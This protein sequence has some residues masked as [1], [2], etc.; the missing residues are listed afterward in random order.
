M[1]AREQRTYKAQYYWWSQAFTEALI[2][3]PANKMKILFTKTDATL[4]L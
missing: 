1:Y 4:V 3:Y 2:I